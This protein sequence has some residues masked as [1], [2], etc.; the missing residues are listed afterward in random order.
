MTVTAAT[1]AR[2]KAER[3]RAQAD[4]VRHDILLKSLELFG[5][6]GFAKTNIGDIADCCGMSPGNLYR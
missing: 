5:H 3:A 1:D 2:L 4:A 6:Y